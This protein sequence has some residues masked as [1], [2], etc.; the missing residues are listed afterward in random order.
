[1]IGEGTSFEWPLKRGSKLDRDTWRKRVPHRGSSKS[2]CAEVGGY[3]M[4]LRTSMEAHVAGKKEQAGES[5]SSPFLWW[6]NPSWTWRNRQSRRDCSW[7]SRDSS[8]ANQMVSSWNWHLSGSNSRAE[9]RQSS[10]TWKAAP[11]R[12][13]ARRL[14]QIYGPLRI[15]SDFFSTWVSQWQHL[16]PK[17]FN[18]FSCKSLGLL[19]P[20]IYTATSGR[21]QSEK[22]L[23]KAHLPKNFPLSADAS[24]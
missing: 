3:L 21:L 8:L 20:G 23:K 13:R 7:R 18:S 6:K 10:S 2:R 15:F 19:S 14:T 5:I 4:S 22:R 9:I 11:W 17:T 16:L 12:D 1:M 24:I